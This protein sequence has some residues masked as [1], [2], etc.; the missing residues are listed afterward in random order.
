MFASKLGN[1]APTTRTHPSSSSSP[2]NVYPKDTLRHFTPLVLIS[3]LAIED[4]DSEASLRRTWA[5]EASAVQDAHPLVDQGD[6]LA[7]GP[8]S[9]LPELFTRFANRSADLVNWSQA[10]MEIGQQQKGAAPPYLLNIQFVNRDSGYKLP[11]VKSLRP[12]NGPNADNENYQDD[13]VNGPVT[14][15]KWQYPSGA[16]HSPL[17]PLT[18]GSEL[19]LDGLISEK[20]IQKYLHILPSTFI[21]IRVLTTDTKT[22]EDED[23]ADAALAAELNELKLQLGKRDVKLIVIIVAETLPNVDPSLNDRIY[24]LRKATGLAARTGLFFLPPSSDVELETL[25]ETVCQLSYTYAT[26]EFYSGAARKIRKKRGGKPK[27]LVLTP[28]EAAQLTTSPISNAAWE[29][30]YHYKLA[31]LA[32]LRQEIEA[33]TKAYETTYEMALELFETLHPPAQISGP[34]WCEFRTFMDLLAFRIV[35]LNLYTGASHIAYKKFLVHLNGISLILDA[36]GF[37]RDAFAYKHWRAVQLKLLANLIDQTSGAVFPD[38][39]SVAPNADIF[40]PGDCL[41]RSGSLY[42]SSARLQFE[43]LARDYSTE[44]PVDPFMNAESAN[45]ESITSGLKNSLKWACRDF[46]YGSTPNERSAAYAMYLLGEAT[47]MYDADPK[48]ALDHYKHAANVYRRGSYQSQSWAELLKVVLKR[49]VETAKSAEDYPE[50][51]LSGIEL[52]LL[53]D[54]DAESIEDQVAKLE[55]PSIDLSQYQRRLSLYSAQFVFEA[56]DSHIGLPMR[57]QLLVTCNCPDSVF[58]DPFHKLDQLRIDISG[59]LASIL[60]THNDALPVSESGLVLVETTQLEDEKAAYADRVFKAEANLTFKR[61][62][63]IVFELAQIPKQLGSASLLQVSLVSSHGDLKL[64]MKLPVMPNYSG[65]TSWYSLSSENKRIS[66]TIRTENPY[67]VTLSPRP[68]LV[69]VVLDMKGSVGLGETVNFNAVVSN[70]EPED[71]ILNLQAKGVTSRG[72]PLTVAYRTD[73]A[74]PPSD[75]ISDLSVPAHTSQ[76]IPLTIQVPVSSITSL[77]IDFF[78]AYFTVRDDETQIKDNISIPLDVFKPFTVNFEVNPRFDP[79]SWPNF[80]IP[81]S[82]GDS[83]DVLMGLT[84]AIKKQWQLSATVL[85]LCETGTAIEVL[86]SQLDFVTPVEAKCDIIRTPDLTKQGI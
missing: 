20:W 72:D 83:N 6:H 80:F 41:P 50:F 10:A 53:D 52:A 79:D 71:I 68:S 18:P 55:S 67:S 23:T 82:P 1:L 16:L 22:K 7:L 38:S 54:S 39:T 48:A 60:I 57:A 84:P 31:A 28:A 64:A 2:M 85:C 36:R 33:S 21:S 26:T 13:G 32:E 56:M 37:K 73:R 61:G 29:I 11:P 51:I 74:D 46:S 30:R 58:K 34:R 35:K 14:N 43:L 25:A 81:S 69:K 15:M 62:Q 78:L 76:S 66:R 63:S 86:G 9:K 27:T 40:K 47:S 44:G 77:S 24:N 5:V 8:D 59:E 17:S 3:G 42:L 70:L 49:V 4:P 75:L 45:F 12:Y 19:Y 65:M